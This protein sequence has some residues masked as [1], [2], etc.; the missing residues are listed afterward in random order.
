MAA[1][2]SSGFARTVTMPAFAVM[3]VGLGV[4]VLVPQVGLPAAAASLGIMILV[5]V[6]LTLVAISVSRRGITKQL[7]S[8][9]IQHREG[10]RYWVSPTLV[11][12]M[13][14]LPLSEQISVAKVLVER[15]GVQSQS[16]GTLDRAAAILSDGDTAESDRIRE[17]I[18]LLA[19]GPR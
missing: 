9:V 14:Q 12:A 7:E 4:A 6:G 5:S 8:L 2:R 10:L 17:L 19:F 18:E 15:S 1:R 16:S 3:V 13:T 11:V